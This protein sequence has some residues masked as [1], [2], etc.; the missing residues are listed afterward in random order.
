MFLLNYLG[1]NHCNPK[2]RI[3]FDVDAVS[4]LTFQKL[5]PVGK[6]GKRPGGNVRREVQF[7]QKECLSFSQDGLDLPWRAHPHCIIRRTLVRRAHWQC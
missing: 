4:T 2:N 1:Q 7:L 3:A 5:P 6:I